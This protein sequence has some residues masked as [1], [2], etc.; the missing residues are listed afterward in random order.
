MS[1]RSGAILAFTLVTMAVGTTMAQSP[2]RDDPQSRNDPQGRGYARGR[3]DT[4]GREVQVQA[5]QQW[6]Q[7]GVM[8]SRGQ[9]VQF[10]TTGE[11]T[12]N[13]EGS[14]RARP[15]GATNNQFDRNAPL[16]TVPVGTLIGRIGAAGR[17]NQG[18]NR[19]FS[20]GD[21][22]S[23]VMPADGELLL[24][25]N[26]SNVN[27]NRG[28]F[29]V[30]IDTAADVR[31][32]GRGYGNDQIREF[33]VPARQQWVQTGI[34]VRQGEVIRFEASGEVTLNQA[35]S[36]RARPA[37]AT[38]NQFDRDAALPTVPVGALIGRVG[39]PTRP[40]QRNNR[41]FLIGDQ[42]S[43]VM[44]FDGELLLGVNDSNHDDNNGV[45]I[46]RVDRRGGR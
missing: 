37:G 29:T 8:V 14:L 5:R 43:I 44:P 36:L 16:P 27:D 15:A 3:S 18:S 11:V 33:Q 39:D 28:A 23:V 12:L 4:P 35:G 30:W 26:D 41:A 2:R 1:M 42:V 6:S 24:G 38:N 40:G 10:D 17:G 20:I 31:G 45:F 9:T 19:P 34:I 22:T 46:V 13:Q 32:Q 7:T 25:I 21:R